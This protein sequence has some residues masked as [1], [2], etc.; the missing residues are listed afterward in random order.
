VLAKAEP[1]V[2]WMDSRRTASRPAHEQGGCIPLKPPLKGAASGLAIDVGPQRQD[3]LGT[4]AI[5][6]RHRSARRLTQSPAVQI[7][8][9]T[10]SKRHQPPRVTMR[11]HVERSPKA[12]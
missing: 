1:A 9:Q 4:D 7:G 3:A 10:G 12:A 6:K 2:R 8:Q 5:K 11:P